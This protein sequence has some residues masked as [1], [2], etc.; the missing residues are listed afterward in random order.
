MRQWRT[1]ASN[2]HIRLTDTEFRRDALN[3][4]TARSVLA[5]ILFGER[6]CVCDSGLQ[7][8]G[9]VARPFET[10]SALSG[11]GKS[12]QCSSAASCGAAR[13]AVACREVR[14]SNYGD[15]DFERYGSNPESKPTH[16]N[17]I[18]SIAPEDRTGT[19]SEMGKGTER[20]EASSG[21][22]F[23]PCQAHHVG[24]SPQEDCGGSAG[25]VGEGTGGEEEGSVER[26]RAEEIVDINRR[27]YSLTQCP[28]SKVGTVPMYTV[29]YT[30]RTQTR[31][32]QRI[33]NFPTI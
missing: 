14:P 28:G 1:A 31:P 7:S 9:K 4:A 2:L 12:N 25:A 22:C 8:R 3:K 6:D 11:S 27:S 33:V 29:L 32:W 19:K 16:Q 10:S 21:D 5:M 13:S 17:R 30:R 23:G 24:I 18:G 15:R 26:R 20:I